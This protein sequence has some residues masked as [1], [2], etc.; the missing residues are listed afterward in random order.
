MV[1]ESKRV[2]IVDIA[3][4][5][6]IS[7]KAV[8]FGLN[9]TGRLSDAL[10]QRIKAMA[11]EL[12]YRPNLAARRLV[13]GGSYLVGAMLPYTQAS[14]TGRLLDGIEVVVQREGIGLLLGNGGTEPS[15][16]ERSIRQ[17][18]EYGVSGLVVMPLSVNWQ[19]YAKYLAD[20]RLPVV[21]MMNPQPELG[22][23][24]VEVNNIAA[25]CDAVD[26]LIGLGHKKIGFVSQ[27]DGDV[28]LAQRTIGYRM[29][30]EKAGIP[31]NPDWME[32]VIN[33]ADKKHT[34]EALTRLLDRV[35][36]LTALFCVT[37]Y[38]AVEALGI[39][40]DRGVKVPEEFSLIG[41]DG[42]DIATEQ[43][44]LPITTMAQPQDQIGLVAGSM[45]LDMIS[46][47]PGNGISL[48]CKLVVGATTAPCRQ[49]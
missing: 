29:A 42:M 43:V 46:G 7:P 28:S 17:M 6:G 3:R 21:Q 24:Y 20:V 44:L 49:R 23:S 25:S 2:T 38:I 10:R 32:N 35:P 26:Y 30:L 34:Q 31:L 39:L 12:G 4:R 14:F 37:D 40:L 8:S 41:F 16:V 15:G 48:N 47:K 9:D 18:L 19:M 33:G 1:H 27:N 45:L 22:H 36:D 13:T 5:L 11:K